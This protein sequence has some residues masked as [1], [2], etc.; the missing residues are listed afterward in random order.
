LTICRESFR[1]TCVHSSQFRNGAAF[2]GR[3]IL[4]A[5]SG[6]SA[7]EIALDL[8][9]DGER[10]ITMLAAGARQF[11]P[12][13]AFGEVM[14]RAREAGTAPCLEERAFADWSLR[15]G[16]PAFDAACAK[17]SLLMA[18]LAD[19]TSSV[20]IDTP[21]VGFGEAQV[22]EGRISVFDHGAL[23]LMRTGRIRVCAAR[24]LALTP[25]GARLSDGSTIEVDAVVLATGFE[26]RFEELL[27]ER[28]LARAQPGKG[29]DPTCLTPL[30][31]GRDRS[32]VDGS[33]FVVGADHCV[34]GGMAMGMQGWSCGFRVAQQLGKLPRGA[35]FGLDALP[36]RQADVIAAD[37]AAHAP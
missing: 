28:F 1:G 23:A 20:G 24:L 35:S 9:S 13:G 10:A 14:R 5:G 16:E 2:R 21:P 30:T 3:H 7:C 29:V 26:P 4:V 33:L 12:M 36:E 8:A 37:A 34:N 18:S 22:A 11:V 32:T 17:R 31:D 27:P 6:N 25:S 15:H 19:D